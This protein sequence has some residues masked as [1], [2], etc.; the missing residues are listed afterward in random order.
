MSNRKPFSQEAIDEVASYDAS[1]IARARPNDGGWFATIDIGPNT[2]ISDA[3]PQGYAKTEQEACEKVK[4]WLLDDMAA[5]GRI[6]KKQFQPHW[7]SYDMKYRLMKYWDEKA[8]AI[9]SPPPSSGG[10]KI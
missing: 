4:E 8:A 9:P 10:P 1:I 3:V 5:G 7:S 2:R 6:G